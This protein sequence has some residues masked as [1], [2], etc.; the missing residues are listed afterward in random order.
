M[1]SRVLPLETSSAAI[2][3]ERGRI[4]VGSSSGGLYCLRASDGHVFWRHDFGSSVSSRP[5]YDPAK[6]VVYFGSDDGYVYCLLGR[7][8]RILW[9]SDLKAEV[10]NEPRLTQE[11][12]YVTAADGTVAALNNSTGQMIWSYRKNPPT[13]FTSFGHPGVALVENKLATGFA[14]G[15][16]V[17]LD[18]SDGAVIWERDLGEDVNV[19]ADQSGSAPLLD[20]DATPV[21]DGDTVYAASLAGGLY[22]LDL[23]SGSVRW[24]RNDI[25]QATGITL[26]SGMLYVSRA[27]SGITAVDARDG[28]TLWNRRFDAGVLTTPILYNDIILLADSQGG[29]YAVRQGDGEFLEQVKT[30][31]GFFAPLAIY[32]NWAFA[33][34]NGGTLLALLIH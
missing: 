5:L 11:A 15:E 2:D 31:E 22:A 33:L 7:S 32:K 25:T 21:V 27:A 16:V 34:S 18:A 24:R 13:G 4:F 30:G 9:K 23:S 20:V 10:V 19:H 6:D 28:S 8:G 12:L 17:V 3:A 1:N 14:T 26:D 29:V